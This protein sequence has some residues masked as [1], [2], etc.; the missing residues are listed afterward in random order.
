MDLAPLWVLAL[1]LC[2]CQR[3]SHTLFRN[4]QDLVLYLVVDLVVPLRRGMAAIGSVP[5]L[6]VLE[7]F[8]AI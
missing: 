6:D 3:T 8:A 5:N 2:R 1:V 7:F 4:L